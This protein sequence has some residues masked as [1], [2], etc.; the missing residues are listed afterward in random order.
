MG[1]TNNTYASRG[2]MYASRNGEFV[3]LSDALAEIRRVKRTFIAAA[4]DSF[5]QTMQFTSVDKEKFFEELLMK[6]L[7][8]SVEIDSRYLE[9]SEGD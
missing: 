4:L 9:N 2:P 5:R 1:L 8:E 7:N 6:K 3:F